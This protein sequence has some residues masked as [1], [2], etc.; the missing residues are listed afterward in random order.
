MLT[1]NKQVGKRY[2]YNSHIAH[3]ESKLI[4]TRSIS[5]LIMT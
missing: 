4:L 1:L 2:E 5:F 3:W